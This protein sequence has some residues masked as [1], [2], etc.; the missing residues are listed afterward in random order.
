MSRRSIL[1]LKLKFKI[2]IFGNFYGYLRLH[3]F[4]KTKKQNKGIISFP[5]IAIVLLMQK[6]II[7]F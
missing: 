4:T 3:L 6:L 5:K 2:F 7:Y 1:C